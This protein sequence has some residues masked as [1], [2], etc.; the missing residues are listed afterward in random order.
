MWGDCGGGIAFAVG[1]SSIIYAG[2]KNFRG[3]W[4]FIIGIGLLGFALGGLGSEIDDFLANRSQNAAFGIFLFVILSTCGILLLL[5]A[6]KLHRC[7]L[8]L[9]AIQKENPEL[10]HGI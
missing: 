6:R 8:K 2:V 4:P 1:G 7:V 5:S 3:D 9:E 10:I